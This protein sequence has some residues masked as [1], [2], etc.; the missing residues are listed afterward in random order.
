MKKFKIANIDIIKHDKAVEPHVMINPE[1]GEEVQITMESE[2]NEYAEQGFV[3]PNA[4]QY[5]VGGSHN[6]DSTIG[7][8]SRRKYKEG[9][10]IDKYENLTGQYIEQL[11][12]RLLHKADAEVERDEYIKFPNQ[13]IRKAVGKTHEQGG[14]D[15]DLPNGSQILSDHL[16]IGKTLAKNLK[17]NNDLKVNATDTYAKVLEKYNKKLGLDSLNKTQ[18]DLYKLLEKEEKTSDKRTKNINAEYLN[19]KILDIENKKRILKEDSLA[20]FDTLFSFQEASK[21]QQPREEFRYGGLSEKKIKQIAEKNGLTLEKAMFLLGGKKGYYENGDETVKKAVDRDYELR[22]HDYTREGNVVG[23]QQRLGTY[24]GTKG[25]KDPEIWGRTQRY[26]TLDPQLYQKY[27]SG[28][29]IT[30]EQVGQFQQDWQ[31]RAQANIDYYKRL[32]PEAY[33]DYEKSVRESMFTADGGWRGF[34]KKLGVFTSSRPGFAHSMYDQ[35]TTDELKKLGITHISQLVKNPMK[36][37]AAGVTDD[38]L[39]AATQLLK[40]NPDL[41]FGLLPTKTKAVVKDEG[42]TPPPVVEKKDPTA[43]LVSTG[44][45]PEPYTPKGFI[46]PDASKPIPSP[47]DPHLLALANLGRITP[48]RQGIENIVQALGTSQRLTEEQLAGLPP[49][50]RA[51]AMASLTANTQSTLAD[52]ILKTNRANVQSQQ[53][54]DLYN[55]R[56]GDQERALQAQYDRDFEKRQYTA[57]GIAEENL[58]NWFDYNNRVA[59]QRFADTQNLNYLDMMSDDYSLDLFAMPHFD[60]SYNWQLNDPNKNIT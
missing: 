25:L 21:P 32:H 45:T 22:Q 3:M 16:K 46:F 15:L 59:Q 35:K 19:S 49:S 18:E 51:A 28:E 8:S 10:E 53:A 33:A 40:E 52:S 17:Q 37:Q 60:P 57:K 27:F 44:F 36:A 9:G 50:Q 48:V 5:K 7:Y 34:D 4:P 39:K 31:R 54:A 43:G 11:P 14:V 38:Q 26:S 23:S 2:H 12:S 1:T 24:Y 20:M 55:V 41:D 6:V 30:E 47:M 58:L 42:E 56:A 13:E 29:G